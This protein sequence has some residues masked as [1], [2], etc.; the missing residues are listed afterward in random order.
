[1]GDRQ[2]SGKAIWHGRFDQGPSEVTQAFV[3]SLSFDRRLY[4]HDIAGS[5]AHAR[6]LKAV[7]LITGK[8]LRAIEAGL[9]VIDDEIS[10]GK[11]RFRKSDEDIHMAIEAALID[12]A[13]EAGKMLHT[14][15]SRNDQVA[16][17]LRLYVR[18]AIDG[19]LV[20]GLDRLAGAFV[21][22]SAR[23]GEAVMP[24]YTHLQPAQPVVAGAVVLA[25]V[26][27]LERD[28]E[29]LLDCRK[30]VDCC[31][32][33]A[34]ALAGTTL[35]I[36]R[37]FVAKQLGFKRV[38]R[39]S[40]DA[41]S[42]RDF[43]VELT[44]CLSTIALHLSRWAEEWIIWSSGEFGFVVFD[45]A[46]CT[47]SSMMPQKRNPDVLELVRGKSGGVFGQLVALLTMLKGLPLAYNRDMQ[48]D[49]RYVFE[50]LDI[51]VASLEIAAAV[52]G[53]ARFDEEAMAGRLDEGYLEATGL[54]EYL[55][56]RGVAFRAAH[57]VVGR[58][59]AHCEKIGK[60][61]RD[62][63]LDEL[64]RFTDNIGS[65]VYTVLDASRLVKAYRS[66]GSAGVREWRKQLRYWQRVVLTR[67]L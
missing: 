20:S 33:G 47:G 36:D 27:A 49:K 3:E 26:E 53:S 55:V 67:S 50:A 39:N 4:R 41:V 38:C 29:R 44:F 35:G 56:G 58:I 64:G 14:G 18:D 21:D 13:G 1:M 37:R 11:F 54:A 19:P 30:R 28:R 62:L 60:K 22:L 45:D 25:Y 65:D 15:R 57:E 6:M 51:V 24:G 46:Y 10:S 48:D 59:V 23:Q 40:I 61:L 34:A 32:L 63:S 12:K 31:P 16:L 2:E 7:G 9:K 8:A 43:A 5:I 42:D 66:A 17:D 52:V